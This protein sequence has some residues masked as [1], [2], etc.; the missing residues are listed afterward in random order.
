VVTPQY[1][2]LMGFHLQGLELVRKGLPI[3][4]HW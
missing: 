4:N 1:E 2:I 3:K